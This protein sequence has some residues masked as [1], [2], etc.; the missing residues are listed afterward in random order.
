MVTIRQ[1][2]S[3]EK[4]VAIVFYY[5]VFSSLLT[6]LPLPFVWVTPNW[7]D[8]GLLILLGL[9]G[10]TSQYFMTRALEL[11]KAAVIGP[12]NYISLLW[13][14][15]FGWVIWGDIPAPHVFAGAAVVV[16]SGLFVLFREV[17][18]SRD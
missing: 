3:T 18:K 5:T 17:R 9:V 13:A 1:L 14:A 6:A 15:L 2:N 7:L 12:F 4:P 10:G 16:A 8:W 11:A